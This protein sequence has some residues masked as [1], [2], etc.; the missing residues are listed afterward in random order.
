MPKIVMLIDFFLSL[1]KVPSLC[2]SIV[3]LPDCFSVAIQPTY[4][5]IL[6]ENFGVKQKGEI[7]MLLARSRI[8]I[9][10][11]LLSIANPF[12]EI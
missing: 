1:C 5:S 11:G 4:S 6:Q 12:L 9:L 3:S 8:L 2:F 10:A 7:E